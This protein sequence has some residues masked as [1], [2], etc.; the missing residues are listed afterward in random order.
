MMLGMIVFM[1][2]F[3]LMR[4]RNVVLV[5][6]VFGLVVGD[7]VIWGGVGLFVVGVVFLFFVFGVVLVYLVSLMRSRVVIVMVVVVILGILIFLIGV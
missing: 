7:F 2:R 6:D 4:V 1:G 5:L 3:L